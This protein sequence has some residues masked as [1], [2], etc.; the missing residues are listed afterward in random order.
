MQRCSL[1]RASSFAKWEGSAHRECCTV[2]SCPNCRVKR[3]RAGSI[4]VLISSKLKTYVPV[5][6]PQAPAPAQSRFFLKKMSSI[7]ERMEKEGLMSSCLYHKPAITLLGSM[8]S[9]NLNPFSSPPC[10]SVLIIW[11]FICHLTVSNLQCLHLLENSGRS[12]NFSYNLQPANPSR[13]KLKLRRPQEGDC[14]QGARR[15]SADFKFSD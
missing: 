3:C 5:L 11:L 7:F 12:Q 4:T 9:P 10:P 6:A 2:V 8:E 13:N 1:H 15:A 14:A